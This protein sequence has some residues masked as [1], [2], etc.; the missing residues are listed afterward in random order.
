[1]KTTEYWLMPDKTAFAKTNEDGVFL[2]SKSSPMEEYPE[3]LLNMIKDKGGYLK[4]SEGDIYVE[5]EKE[6]LD[7]IANGL[8]DKLVVSDNTDLPIEQQVVVDEELNS[9]VS[10]TKEKKP[11][12]FVQKPDH[13]NGHIVKVKGG[14]EFEY[15]TIEFIESWLRRHDWMPIEAKYSAG[16]AVK[17]M[18]RVGNKPEDGKTREEKAAE[19]FEKISW[20]CLRAAKALRGELYK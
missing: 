6:Q 13:Y 17:Y 19:D 20:Y 5:A 10:L 18:D 14:S 9:K 4:L 8:G 2:D 12:D 1:M 16:N 3:A 15:E 7:V 11:Y